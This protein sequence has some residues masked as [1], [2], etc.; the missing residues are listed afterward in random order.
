MDA[1]RHTTKFSEIKNNT[2]YDLIFDLD[3]TS[4]QKFKRYKKGFKDF[5]K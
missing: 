4:T 5:Q 3:A 2:Q 1:I